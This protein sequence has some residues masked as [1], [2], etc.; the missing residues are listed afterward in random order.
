M[1]F[2]ILNE[3]LTSTV[4]DLFT[5]SESAVYESKLKVK[6][7]E[8]LIKKET[9]QRNSSVDSHKYSIISDDSSIKESTKINN[10]RTYKTPDEWV[11]IEA[12]MRLSESIAKL[13]LTEEVLKNRQDL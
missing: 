7:L 10:T 4:Y 8:G 2:D 6:E 13:R 3:L 1:E 11:K 9:S 12:P 5:N